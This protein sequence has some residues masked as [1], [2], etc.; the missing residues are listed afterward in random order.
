MYRGQTPRLLWCM[1]TIPTFWRISSTHASDQLKLYVEVKDLFLF[2]QNRMS[3][4]VEIAWHKLAL[5]QKLKLESVADV[6]LDAKYHQL[7]RFEIKM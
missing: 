2:G 3:R 4:H 5:Y 6:L 1:V 7:L